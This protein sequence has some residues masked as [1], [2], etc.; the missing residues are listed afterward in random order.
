MP[1][2]AI[3]APPPP[4]V[5]C[6]HWRETCTATTA[7]TWSVIDVLPYD[8]D[9]SHD[10]V[11]SPRSV[12]RA[13]PRSGG[14]RRRK[15]RGIDCGR[16]HS[17]HLICSR[18]QNLSTTPR[19]TPSG[20]GCSRNGTDDASRDSVAWTTPST[21][22]PPR[23]PATTG[24]Q[25]PPLTD[26]LDRPGRGSRDSH[27]PR[28]GLRHRVRPAIGTDRRPEGRAADDTHQR[29]DAARPGRGRRDRASS[30]S[31]TARSPH[32]WTCQAALNRAVAGTDE[33]QPGS[34]PRPPGL[35]IR[36]REKREARPGERGGP[37]GSEVRA[38]CR[39]R[40]GCRSSG[41]PAVPPCS[42]PRARPR[43]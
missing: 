9:A 28:A 24:R 3:A 22:A 36:S 34:H 23:H 15:A 4:A 26:R 21:G 7:F 6:Q 10:S 16:G 13:A 35:A 1:V 17:L 20:G 12:S 42:T 31:R 5:P 29:D 25:P 33:S 37:Q 11:D 2:D 38:G 32:G 14:A 18:G 8:G 27:P 19:T 39:P 40:H 43:P 30:R 41:R